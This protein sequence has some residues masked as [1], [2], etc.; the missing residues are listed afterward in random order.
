MAVTVVVT[1]YKSFYNF[2]KLKGFSK[3]L[4]NYPTFIYT[5]SSINRENIRFNFLSLT[6][7]TFY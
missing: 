5:F 1:L 4:N 6:N 2:S 7:I 3:I